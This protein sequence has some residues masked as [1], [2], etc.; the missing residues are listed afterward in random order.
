M[1]EYIV[2]VAFRLR[3]FDSVIVEANSDEEV[4]EKA[5]VAA[6]I[7]MEAVS[8]P[9]HIDLAERWQGVIAFIDR[10]TPDG[11][12]EV[13]EDLEFDDDQINVPTVA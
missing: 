13:I 5:K 2:K 8:Y 6:K 3:A 1:T 10:I 11:C 4:I 12:E 7:V 9:E